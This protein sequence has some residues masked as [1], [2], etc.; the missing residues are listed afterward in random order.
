MIL[1]GTAAVEAVLEAFKQR[2]DVCINDLVVGAPAFLDGFEEATALKQAEVFT[3]D[4]GCDGAAFSE[5]A[6][7]VAVV[8]K[9]LEDAKAHGVCKGAETVRSPFQG[10]KFLLRRW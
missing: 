4:V 7:A 10:D 9:H 1:F 5:F 8:Q 6:D 3:G 2:L